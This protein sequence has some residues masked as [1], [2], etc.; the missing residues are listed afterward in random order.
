[1]EASLNYATIAIRL[2]LEN[3]KE[4]DSGNE[5]KIASSSIVGLAM[6]ERS[7]GFWFGVKVSP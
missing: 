5:L 7:M 6:T 2:K 1:M 4:P 3:V